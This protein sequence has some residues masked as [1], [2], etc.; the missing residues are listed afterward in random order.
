MYLLT[1]Q[2]LNDINI[3][4]SIIITTNSKVLL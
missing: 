2:Q 4:V 1:L 3:D